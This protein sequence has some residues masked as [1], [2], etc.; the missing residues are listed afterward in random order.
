[1]DVALGG[2]LTVNG[3]ITFNANR[4]A[5]GNSSDYAEII[6]AGALNLGGAVRTI[7]VQSI[8][9][10]ADAAVLAGSD[11]DIEVIIQN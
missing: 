7:T 6:G 4:G 8:N 2:V 11:A 1:V 3:N 5:T 10:Q 9:T